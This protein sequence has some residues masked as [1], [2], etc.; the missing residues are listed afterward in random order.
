VVSA[1]WFFLECV[2]SLKLEV[3]SGLEVDLGAQNQCWKC[4]VLTL[5][6]L[7][8]VLATHGSHRRAASCSPLLSRCLMDVQFPSCNMWCHLQLLRALKVT[9]QAKYVHMLFSLWPF[10]CS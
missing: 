9:A 4:A 6:H 7:Q 2:L 8:A 10:C 1:A 3:C 5:V